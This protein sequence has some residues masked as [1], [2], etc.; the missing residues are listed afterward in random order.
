MH[1]LKLSPTDCWI[2][3]DSLAGVRAAKAAGSFTVAITTTFE[4]SALTAAGADMIVKSF[5][6]LQGMMQRL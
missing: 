3:E 6:E 4:A 1:D 5:S 2:I